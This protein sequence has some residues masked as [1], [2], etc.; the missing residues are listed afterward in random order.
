M[1]DK[2]QFGISEA[3]QLVTLPVDDSGTPDVDCLAPHPRP[4]DWIAPAVV[5]LVKLPKPDDTLTHYSEPKLV[6][7]DDR[8]ERDWELIKIPEATLEQQKSDAARAAIKSA[9]SSKR[10]LLYAPYTVE[11]EGFSLA[12]GESD[13]NAF[14][15]LIT[16]VN[17]AGLP[18]E[19]M[20]TI[21]DA[22][23]GIY[24][25]TVKR[26]REVVVAYGMEIFNRWTTLK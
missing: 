20:I 15:R 19:H 12:T 7:Y 11:P 17:A 24:P 3:Q 18:D 16:L 1:S 6:W 14:T 23:G 22:T 2:K 21:S 8:V 10:K 25:M 9:A 4:D 5:P 13:Q 26:M